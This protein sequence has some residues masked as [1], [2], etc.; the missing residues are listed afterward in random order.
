ML[1][2]SPN[3]RSRLFDFANA[4]EEQEAPGTRRQVVQG[5]LPMTCIHD[6]LRLMSCTWAI[7]AAMTG[8]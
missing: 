3:T 1:T 2:C 6:R 5:S 7:T 4:L 8:V